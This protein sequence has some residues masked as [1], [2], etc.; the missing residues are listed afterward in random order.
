MTFPFQNDEIFLHEENFRYDKETY[1]NSEEA[2]SDIN[3]DFEPISFPVDSDV[4]KVDQEDISNRNP[5]FD[6]NNEYNYL[7]VTAKRRNGINAPVDACDFNNF[8]KREINKT[9]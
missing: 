3:H 2:M 8:V 7:W 4:E 5:R 9:P 6:Y 1:H